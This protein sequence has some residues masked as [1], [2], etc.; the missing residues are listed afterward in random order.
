M[1]KADKETQTLPAKSVRRRPASGRQR[2]PALADSAPSP[3][4]PPSSPLPASWGRRCPP[5]FVTR[6]A[7]MRRSLI[8]SE[9]RFVLEQYERSL[10]MPT[11]RETLCSE[12]AS[13]RRR[14]FAEPLFQFVQF[15]RCVIHSKH[16]TFSWSRRVF[17]IFFIYLAW[18]AQ[19]ASR[20]PQY[21][22]LLVTELVTHV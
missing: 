10:S 1:F 21:R 20:S 9:W 14:S 19:A 4:P 18:S 13:K 5:A 2:R 22:P 17:I 11:W 12:R 8:S 3:T 6:C 7:F 15:R 16:C